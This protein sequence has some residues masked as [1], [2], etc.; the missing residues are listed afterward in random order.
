MGGLL[1][2]PTSLRARLAIVGSLAGIY[3]L[4]YTFYIFGSPLLQGRQPQ[5]TLVIDDTDLSP[6][7]TNGTDD[8]EWNQ[9]R[10]LLVTAMFQLADSK[11]VEDTW[12]QHFLGK[13]TSDIYIFTTPALESHILQLRGSNN[14]IIDTSYPTPFDIPPLKGKEDAY[15]QMQ[16]KDRQKSK[17]RTPGLSALLNSKPFFLHTALNNST[18]VAYDYVFW[19]DIANFHEE[20]QYRQWPSP[21]R[22]RQVWE[23]GSRLTGTNPDELMFIPMWGLPHSTFVFWNENMGPIDNDFSQGKSLFRSFIFLLFYNGNFFFSF[24]RIF[25][26]WSTQSYRLVRTDVLRLS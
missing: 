10:I 4:A 25:L 22:V 20:H 21:A 12:I 1:A 5:P 2:L 9:P 19:S 26:W 3:I 6:V 16:K 17:S 15:K 24:C 23:E 13:V 11:P 8:S 14:I 7:T 18:N